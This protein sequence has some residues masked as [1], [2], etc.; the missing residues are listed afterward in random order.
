MMGDDFISAAT[1]SL[2]R[3]EA[4]VT[5]ERVLRGAV[6][7]ALFANAFLVFVLQPHISKRLLPV[8]GGSAEVWIVC[9]L[10][11]QVAL[12]GGYGLAAAARRIPLTA[13]LPLHL[14]LIA[15]A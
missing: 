2:R 9:S 14:A 11:F 8:L 3:D 10:F 5:R 7:T 13:A 12:L 4:G 1:I 15:I 6:A